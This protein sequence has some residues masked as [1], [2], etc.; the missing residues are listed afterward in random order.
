MRVLD[1]GIALL[2]GRHELGKHPVGARGPCRPAVSRLHDTST[3]DGDRHATRIARIDADRMNGRMLRASS[4]PLASLG[5]FPQRTI[6]LPR[7]T[8]IAREK[9]PTR[10]RSRPDTILDTRPRRFE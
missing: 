10:S 8:A 5:A 3:G 2:I 7:H 6:Q 1:V 4:K 9:Q